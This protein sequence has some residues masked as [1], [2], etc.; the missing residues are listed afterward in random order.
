MD[1]KL[2]LNR[3]SVKTWRARAEAQG[4]GPRGLS[5]F[6]QYR[7]KDADTA[8]LRIEMLHKLLRLIANQE[9][10]PAD[11]REAIIDVL[12]A[13]K[14]IETTAAEDRKRKREE[15]NQTRGRRLNQT[16]KKLQRRKP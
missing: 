15:E 12:N 1:I 5:R 3:E 10:T 2:S 14:L 9:S 7:L 16:R 6:V 8:D 13:D 4:L 11:L